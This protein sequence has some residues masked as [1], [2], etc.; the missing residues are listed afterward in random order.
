MKISITLILLL[1]FSISE[2]QDTIILDHSVNN[3]FY[4]YKGN[5]V[6]NLRK[7]AEIVEDNQLAHTEVL[8]AQTYKTMSWFFLN[9]GVLVTWGSSGHFG[10]ELNVSNAIGYGI[11]ASCFT[12]GLM[13]YHRK[14]KSEERAV[15]Y[16]NQGIVSDNRKFDLNL[17]FVHNGLGVRLTF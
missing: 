13:S 6:K 3:E 5:K 15:N 12:A 17:A 7:L 16:F 8:N 11:A 1:L 2:A 4:S 10:D 9:I 14:N